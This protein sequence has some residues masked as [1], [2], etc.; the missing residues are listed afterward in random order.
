MPLNVDQPF[1]HATVVGCAISAT[2]N[3]LKSH[4]SK[5]L[6]PS[7]AT[8]VP[9]RLSCARIR[10]RHSSNFLSRASLTNPHSARCPASAQPPATSCL[11]AFRPPA[12]TGRGRGR[13][14]GVQKPA[15]VQTQ[16]MQQTASSHSIT[17]SARTSKASGTVTPIALAVLRL[18]TSSNFVGCSTGRLAGIVSRKRLA[19]NRAVRSAN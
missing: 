2:R 9:K 15:H 6:I 18:I 3:Y 1:I 10:S 4:G 19:A 8:I 12:A 5:T 14:A 7:F 13:H 17:L 11:G 16:A